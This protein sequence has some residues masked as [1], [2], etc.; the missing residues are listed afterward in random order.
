ML[1]V[2]QSGIK[3]HF[4]VI[5]M[6]WPGI[7]PQSPGQLANKL[8]TRSNASDRLKRYWHDAAQYY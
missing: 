6:T 5:G 4:S 3:Y 7:E 2:K 1:S 8:P